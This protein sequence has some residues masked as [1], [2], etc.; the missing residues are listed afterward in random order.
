LQP[1]A[2]SAARLYRQPPTTDHQ[3]QESE[4]QTA[5]IKPQGIYAMERNGKLV[6]FYVED[7]TPE[8]QRGLMIKKDP[9]DLIGP[10][11]E[12]A[13]LVARREQEA[14]ERKAKEEAERL[15]AEADR[16][17]L[18]RFVGV[19]PNPKVKPSEYSQ[20]FSVGYGRNLTI[21]DDGDKLIIERVRALE[22]ERDR[23]PESVGDPSPELVAAAQAQ[24]KREGKM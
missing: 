24:W 19:T 3:Q 5:K 23:K 4:M 20:P 17:M 21:R 13:E 22:S 8:G 7:K 1:Q 2:G 15:I 6:R 11:E 10:Y 9:A 14:I 12:Q 16:L 18:Y